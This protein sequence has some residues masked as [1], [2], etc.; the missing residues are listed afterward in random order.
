MSSLFHLS[1]DYL[2][3]ANI[4]EENGGELT[5]EIEEALE[6][7]KEAIQLKGVN[8]AFVIKDFDAKIEPYIK[9]IERM[10]R[11][12]KAKENAKER[13]KNY[14]KL[15]MERLGITEIKGELLTIRLQNIKA[16]VEIIDKDLIPKKFVNKKVDFIPDKKLIKEA[17][18]SG[19][20]VKGAELKQGK[21]INFK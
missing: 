5:P 17:I 21:S 9:E 13:L 1:Q 6:L 14:L 3:I 20:K 12:V 11:I 7:N 10:Q 18:D 8:I 19:L 15:N 16:S 2:Q 4:L